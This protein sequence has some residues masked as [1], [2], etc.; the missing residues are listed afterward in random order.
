MFKSENLKFRHD[1]FVY[2][3]R[4]NIHEVARITEK[5]YTGTKPGYKKAIN[6]TI[7]NREVSPHQE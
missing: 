4:D 7:C 1:L 2:S 3:P 5:T 6:I